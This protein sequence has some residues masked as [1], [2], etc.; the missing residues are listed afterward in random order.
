M[1]ASTFEPTEHPHRRYNPLTGEWI[2]VSPHRMKRPW[3][4]KVD[5][6][7]PSNVAENSHKSNPL[8][9]GTTRPS[10][11]TNPD[12]TSTFVFTNDFP[13]L[14]PDTPS[15]DDNADELFQYASAQGTCRVMCFHPRSDTTLAK[16]SVAEIGT[17]IDAWIEQLRELGPQY[18]WVQI[19]ENRGEIMG[20]SNPHPHCQIWTTN[21]LPNEPSKKD[22]RQLEYYRLHS[23]PLLCSYLRKEME[24]KKRIVVETPYWV[25]VVPFWAQWPYETM[26]IP[27]RHILR[28]SDV[29][30]NEGTDLAECLKILLQKY[31]RLFDVSFPYSMGWHGAPTGKY[32]GADMDHWQ[33]HAVFYPP[34]LRSATVQKFMVG[35]EMLAC[36]Q[37]DITPEQAADKLRSLMVD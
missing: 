32:L 6:P 4:G 15:P 18:V 28:L 2:L 12:Y 14:M 1:D 23:T 22:S 26:V 36:P 7:S 10:G 25:V 30:E 31:D 3:Q 21:F 13:A 11:Q 20:C 9:P 27:K 8:C 17:V 29:T 34:L 24:K 35:F 19:F 37:R 5:N 33:L 16:M